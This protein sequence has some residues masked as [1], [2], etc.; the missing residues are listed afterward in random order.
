MATL[1]EYILELAN[2]NIA[3]DPPRKILRSTSLLLGR[4]RSKSGSYK[5]PSDVLISEI[6]KI[7][8]KIKLA[9][10]F[11]SKIQ[12][13]EQSTLDYS[14]F[15]QWRENEKYA[16]KLSL[17]LGVKDDI[18]SSFCESF[19]YSKEVIQADAR[20]YSS[21]SA[22]QKKSQAIYQY[23]RRHFQI[24]DFCVHMTGFSSQYAKDLRSEV[25]KYK[26]LEGFYAADSSAFKK[27]ID[28]GLYPF[29]LA[30]Q[31]HLIP[32]SKRQSVETQQILLELSSCPS[33]YAAIAENPNELLHL[34]QAGPKLCSQLESVYL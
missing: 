12:L 24:D 9:A 28:V 15:T 25:K 23:T 4:I 34:F 30:I 7:R 3:E 21:K 18:R 16:Y 27:A 19:H 11:D 6:G 29:L 8:S 20:K 31:S 26:T 10:S 22:W 32:W 13:I 17:A 5:Y 14:S 1:R 33:L 2:I